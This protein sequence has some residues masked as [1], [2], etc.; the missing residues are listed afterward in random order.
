MSKFLVLYLT[1]ASVLEAWMQKDPE[2]RKAEEAKM[3]AEWDAWAE[4]NGSMVTETYG[5]GKTKRVDSNGVSDV[6][7]DVMMY[8]IVE[9]DTH[10]AAAAIF[11]DHPHLQ[12]PEATIDIMAANSLSGS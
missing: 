4:K 6:R 11:V 3:G 12:I 8:S 10:E 7:N 2:E 1:P 5:A 9:A